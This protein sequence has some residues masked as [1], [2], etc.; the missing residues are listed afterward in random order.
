MTDVSCGHSHCL[1][2]TSEGFV[3]TW[4]M[5]KHGQLGLKDNTTRQ[6]PVLLPGSAFTHA[7]SKAPAASEFDG[8]IISQ[9]PSQFKIQKIYA[10]AHSSACIDSVGR[11]YTWGSGANYRTM[12]ASAAVLFEPTV[13]DRLGK[14][15]VKQFAFSDLASAA[16]VVT[17][18]TSVF[19]LEG[20]MKSFSKLTLRGCGFFPSD[21]IVVKFSR[22]GVAFVPPRSAVGNYLRDGVINCRPPRFNEPGEYEV[23]LAV[24]GVDF[25]PDTLR[26]TVYA[27]PTLASMSPHV[28]CLRTIA[29]SN[30]STISVVLV[31]ICIDYHIY[32]LT[33]DGAQFD[34]S[35]SQ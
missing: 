31:R 10:D 27:E 35:A 14:N 4:G 28:G 15:E 33:L 2:L 11:L 19:P 30:G 16:L 24:N 25:L 23:A 22:V 26:I 20:P 32:L 12:H 21:D 6:V 5:N 17:K 7:I 1:A 29:S 8:V 3:Y 9:S 13:V 18:L 34:R